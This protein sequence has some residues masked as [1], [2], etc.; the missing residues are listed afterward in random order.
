VARERDAAGARMRFGPRKGFYAF[1][2]VELLV[3][4]AI[5]GILVALLLPAVQA[6]REAA[7]RAQCSNHLKQ[8][9]IACLNHEG[10]YGILPD[11]GERFWLRRTVVDGRPTVAPNQ[12]WSWAYQIL[13]HFEYEPLWAVKDDF[14]VARTPVSIYFCPSRRA[15][16]SLSKPGGGI[17]WSQSAMIDYAG[18][19]GTDQRGSQGWA[20]L[21]DGKNGTIV[22]RPDGSKFRSGS[23]KVERITDG[24]THTLLVGEKSFNQGRLGEWQAE[25]DAGYVDGW[26][27]DTIRWGYFPP[28]PDWFDATDTTRWG[29]NGTLVPL[30]GA[31][32]GPHPG[33]FQCV[34]VDGS[35]QSISH[36]IALTVFRGLSA[37]DDG[38]VLNRSQL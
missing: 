14:E 32:G 16:E 13:P 35:V 12:N 29:N 3:V 2:L 25:D 1:T 21:G 18:N 7:R 6:A 26:D 31:F 19:A 17:V 8:I 30:R 10:T 33:G 38:E 9:G 27:F 11:G 37:R 28:E 4:I 15:P 34:F 22:R 20:A 24:T 23:V 5:I 36:E